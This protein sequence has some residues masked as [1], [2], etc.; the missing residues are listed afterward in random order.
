[1]LY[2]V[3]EQ[4]PPLVGYL[5]DQGCSD[6]AYHMT[7]LPAV[8]RDQAIAAYHDALDKT[9]DRLKRAQEALE[10]LSVGDALGSLLATGSGE[11]LDLTRRRL[12]KTTWPTGIPTAIALA[13]YA[14][15]RDDGAIEADTLMQALNQQGIPMT[16]DT[17]RNDRRLPQTASL[18]CG[19]LIGAYFA[20]DMDT[21]VEHAC[22]AAAVIDTHPEASA[23]ATAMAVAA[24]WAQRMNRVPGILRKEFLDLVLA[25]VPASI[26]REKLVQARNLPATISV[27]DAVSVLG[28]GSQ[29]TAQDTVPLVLWCAGEW[30]S[31]Y[32]EPIWLAVAARGEHGMLCAL[33]GGIMVMRSGTEPIPW[34]W[35]QARGPLPDWVREAKA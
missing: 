16:R 22:R 32:K 30:F 4:L 8:N 1:M 3:S 23:G 15:L 20:D 21:A 13:T 31:D 19:L 18:I 2:N 24:A 29:N 27:Q 26:T 6:I 11:E 34:S 35:R 5:E 33:V 9:P 10:G 17:E 28:N 12:P 14:V 25:F 7:E